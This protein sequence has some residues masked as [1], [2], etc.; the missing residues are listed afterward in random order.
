M[1]TS[2]FCAFS[3][4]LT[5][6]IVPPVPMPA[7][8]CVMRPSVCR[9]ISGPVVRSCTAGFAGLEYWSGRHAPWI[10]CASRATT[11]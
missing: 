3:A 7:T 11:E 4:R 9:Q 2:G 10:S 1:T 5:P 6:V 8:K